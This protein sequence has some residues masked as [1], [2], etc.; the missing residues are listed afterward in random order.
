MNLSIPEFHAARCVRYRYRYSE[1]ARCLDACPH[2]AISLSD[3]GA[4]IDAD[5]CRNC[6]LCVSA[7]RTGAFAAAGFKPIDM[8]RQAIKTE[9]FSIA[10]APS[11]HAADAVVPCLGAL[12]AP[13]LAYLEKRRL[14][15]SL[16][17]ASLCADCA[18][19]AKGAVQLAANL[20]AVAELRAAAAPEA[21]LPIEVIDDKPAPENRPRFT[22][23]RRHLFRRLLGRGVDQVSA[24][25]AARPAAQPVANKAICAGAYA[26]TEQ[27]EL[28]QIVTGRKDDAPFRVAIHEALPAFDI[29]IGPGCTVCEACFRVCPTGA[30]SITENPG[31]WALLFQRDR[32]V[33]C[34]VCLEVCQPQVLDATA[35]FDLTPDQPPRPLISLAK[36]R[37][38]RCDRFFVSPQPEKTCRVCSDDQDAFSAI[39]GG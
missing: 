25:V 27:R 30:I 11:G 13:L 15:T 12:D 10:C 21:W 4:A 24:A 36:Q 6:A 32:C 20:E 29:S 38:D 2:D 18:H 26:L 9:R 3:S 33:G 14:P 34:A 7:C 37:C 16:L 22:S 8:L 31:D 35:I 39:Y 28:L 23:G 1:C 17:G 19:G 5:K